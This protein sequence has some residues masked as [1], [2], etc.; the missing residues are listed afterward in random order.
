[1]RSVFSMLLVLVALVPTAAL[2][3]CMVTEGVVLLA[4]MTQE[5][6]TVDL[7]SA[8]RVNVRLEAGVG[9][10]VIRG[11][12]EELLEADFTYNVAEWKPSI[13]YSE[14]EGTGRLTIRQPEL[15]GKSIPDDAEN[16]W[17]LRLT[18]SVPL[19]IEMEAGIADANLDLSGL[20]IDRLQIDQGVGSTRV[21]L[22]DE[23]SRDVTIDIDGGV[24]DIVISLP[25]SAGVRLHADMGIGSLTAPGFHE[26]GGAYVNRA[27]GEAEH[28]IEVNIDAGVGSVTLRTSGS[29]SANV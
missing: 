24:G 12:A 11:G 6:E 17:D 20:K 21:T 25:E 10:F 18:G 8:E 3:G 29:G 28:T 4:N 15:E 2:S 1:V 23:I 5:T 14:S 27:Y 16:R 22:G 26:R 9:E 19:E 7:G 13:D